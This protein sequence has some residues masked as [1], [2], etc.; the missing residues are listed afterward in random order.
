M[1]TLHDG[2][3]TC[4]GLGHLYCNVTV[5]RCQHIGDTTVTAR[6]WRDLEVD[7]SEL[8][9]MRSYRSGPFDTPTETIAAVQ[10]MLAWAWW[11]MQEEL[12]SP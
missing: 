9:E 1:D 10:S 11:R 3:N 8:V 6:V 7:D 12:D 5:I 4:L 2:F